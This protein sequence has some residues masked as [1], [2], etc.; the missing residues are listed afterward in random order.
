[1]RFIEQGGNLAE[2]HPGFRYLGDLSATL[3]D[4]HYAGFEDQQP[5]VFVPSDSTVSTPAVACKWKCGEPFLPDL[6]VL[7]QRHCMRPFLHRFVIIRF[8]TKYLSVRGVAIKAL[9]FGRMRAIVERDRGVRRSSN[10]AP[11]RFFRGADL[12]VPPLPFWP[13]PLGLPLQFPGSK[14]A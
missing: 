5:P 2:N 10:L 7:H 9:A 13:G 14:V 11:S 6:G 4:A 3:D 8:L 1:M 12:Q